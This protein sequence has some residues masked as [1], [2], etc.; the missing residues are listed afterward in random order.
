MESTIVTEIDVDYPESGDLGLVIGVG[1]CRLILS[2]GSQDKLV[3]GAY[4]APSNL[5]APTIAKSGGTVKIS[6]ERG[7]SAFLGLLSGVPKLSLALGK[8]KPFTLNLKVGAC[9]INSDL[10]GLPVSRFLIELGAGKVDF[11]FSEPNPQD[12]SLLEVRAGAVSL[13]MRNLANANFTE[14]SV[15]G[16]AASFELDF[17][18]TLRRDAHVRLSTGASAVKIRIPAATAAKIAAEP[19]MGSI[20][21][22]NGFTKKEGSWWNEA[23]MAGAKPVLTI[24][25]TISLGALQLQT[26]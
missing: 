13:L 20:D 3:T 12:M 15:D 22:G 7:P 8:A 2:P 4:D 14:M 26:Q 21:V 17:G 11:D 5:L 9:E 6:Q 10:G 16:G 18:G 25:A 19:V 1:A 23:A 24:H